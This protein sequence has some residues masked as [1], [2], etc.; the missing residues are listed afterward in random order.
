MAPHP[1]WS[2]RL[3]KPFR[4][5]GLLMLM[6][7]AALGLI[8]AAY[9]LWYED[10]SVTANVT[11][12]RFD[13]DWSCQTGFAAAPDAAGIGT[14]ANQTCT[15]ATK[16]TVA[17]LSTA[18]V[19]ST[20]PTLVWTD[21]TDQLDDTA[22]VPTAKY[23]QSCSAAIGNNAAGANDTGTNNTLTFT[24]TDLYPFAGCKFAIDIDVPSG[25]YVPAHFTLTAAANTLQA[26]K[27]LT[28]AAGTCRQIAN[29]LNSASTTSNV[30][31]LN[32]AG[33]A[34]LQLHNNERLFCT[35]LVYLQEYTSTPS[36]VLENQSTGTYS[37]T[38]TI[39]AH[40]F[41]E[42]SP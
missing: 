39:K 8:G 33:T 40:Q 28:P 32:D 42:P 18:L 2:I 31:I 23:I 1:S 36:T 17:V 15:A 34:P 25:N 3:K 19:P 21:F 9:T 4:H 37:L 6:A 5:A 20:N 26:L 22:A 7:I 29:I 16:E 24:L 41:N 12:A 14:S 27:V 35:F 11:T 30:V 13:V 38:A 10:L